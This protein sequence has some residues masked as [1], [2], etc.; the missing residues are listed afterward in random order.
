VDIS[1]FIKSEKKLNV[2]E[3]KVTQDEEFIAEQYG[4]PECRRRIV[5]MWEK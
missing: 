3:I 2:P 1:E 4:N 5:V